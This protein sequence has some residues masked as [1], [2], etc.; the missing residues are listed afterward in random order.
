MSLILS[1]LNGIASAI[2]DG[3]YDSSSPKEAMVCVVC[4]CV[5]LSVYLS[6]CLFVCLSVCLSVC[7]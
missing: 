1:T 2:Q 5:C 3:E 7:V 6:V 4:V